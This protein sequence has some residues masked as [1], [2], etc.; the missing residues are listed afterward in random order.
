VRFENKL[1]LVCGVNSYGREIYLDDKIK[2]KQKEKK[3][4]RTKLV[5]IIK[6]ASG[7]YLSL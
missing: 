2:R 3:H 1:Y 4:V 5:T 7:M 6:Y